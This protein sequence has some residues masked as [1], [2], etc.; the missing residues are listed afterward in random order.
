MRLEESGF[1]VALGKLYEKQGDKNGTVWLEMK[2]FEGYGKKRGSEEPRCLIRAHTSDP[3]SKISTV[4]AS[5]DVVRFQMG[6]SS[7][8]KVQIDKLKRPQKEKKKADAKA[9]D[10]AKEASTPKAA[11]K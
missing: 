3:K 6:L 5:S 1:L 2:R 4:I 10:A 7:V 8:M 11:A 9:L